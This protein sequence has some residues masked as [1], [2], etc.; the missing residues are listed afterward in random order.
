[1]YSG[2][3]WWSLDL[4]TLANG[5]NGLKFKLSRQRMSESSGREG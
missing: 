1:M 5:N 4:K 3:C 2:D